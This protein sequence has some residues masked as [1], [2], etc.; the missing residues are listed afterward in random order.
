MSI[1]TYFHSLSSKDE[2]DRDSNELLEQVSSDSV[3]Y[4]SLSQLIEENNSASIF[5]YKNQ[6][7]MKFALIFFWNSFY[8]HSKKSERHGLL[9]HYA[10]IRLI[11]EII[12]SVSFHTLSIWMNRSFDIEQVDIQY[13]STVIKDYDQYES[14]DIHLISK[15]ILTFLSPKSNTHSCR[16]LHRV[17]LYSVAHP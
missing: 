11:I 4:K 8:R 7:R 1:S 6:S 2:Q 13:P 3:I 12:Q 14:I 5:I 10:I 15:Q 16:F 17:F 9:I